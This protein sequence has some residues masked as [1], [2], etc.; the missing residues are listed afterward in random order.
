MINKRG[1]YL[2]PRTLDEPI[3]ILGLPLDEFIPTCALAIFF[4][5]LGKVILTISMPVLTV[6]GIKMMKKGQGSSWLINLCHWYLP[7]VVMLLLLRHTPPAEN[8]EYIA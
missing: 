7:K 1:L 3:R 8:R 4:F 5:M 2:V 6:V